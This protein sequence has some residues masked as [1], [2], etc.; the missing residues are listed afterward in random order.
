[1]LFPDWHTPGSMAEGQ[2]LPRQQVL[3]RKH[4]HSPAPAP[5]TPPHP[6]PSPPFYHP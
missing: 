4:L 5:P 3:S 6:N 2:A 1:M